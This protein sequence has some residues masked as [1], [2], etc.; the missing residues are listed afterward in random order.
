KELLRFEEYRTPLNCRGLSADG[1]RAL[2]AAQWPGGNI[3][4][5]P[6]T[7]KEIRKLSFAGTGVTNYPFLSPDGRQ[8]LVVESERTVRLWDL[9]T[10]K[11]I[12]SF[13]NPLNDIGMISF[14]P[15]GRYFAFGTLKKGK[16]CLCEAATGQNLCNFEGHTYF[17]RNMLFTPDGRRLL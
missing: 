4:W 6:G 3:L 15:D 2:I 16:M 10:D 7:G 5:D 9:E 17:V 13:D 1:S 11:E 12:R 14:S 8:A